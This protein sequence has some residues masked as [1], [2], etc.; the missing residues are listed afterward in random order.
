MRS[1]GPESQSVLVRALLLAVA[2]SVLAGGVPHAGAASAEVDGTLEVILAD[3]ALGGADGTMARLAVTLTASL[4]VEDHAGNATIEAPIPQAQ[5]GQ[6]ALSPMDLHFFAPRG[7]E[8]DGLYGIRTKDDGRSVASFTW[9]KNA[10]AVGSVATNVTLEAVRTVTLT[11]ITTVIWPFH[12]MSAVEV[13][14]DLPST[15]DLST[16][17]ELT[18]VFHGIPESRHVWRQVVNEPSV[19]FVI[20]PLTE[21]GDPF[22]TYAPNPVT[23]W[24]IVLALTGISGAAWFVGKRLEPPTEPEDEAGLSQGRPQGVSP[25]AS[26]PASDEPQDLPAEG[27]NGPGTP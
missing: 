8:E 18:R 20:R 27:D 7:A 1:S 15:H 4:V 2:A 16:N 19:S 10:P 12:N 5:N 14:V 17:F 26:K 9:H 11:D 21:L 24:L 6:V 23:A 22:P 13:G 3:P 25:T